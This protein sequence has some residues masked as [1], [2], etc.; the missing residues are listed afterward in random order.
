[1]ERFW[2]EEAYKT[3]KPYNEIRAKLPKHIQ[4]AAR[5]EAEEVL[6]KMAIDELRKQAG[7]TQAALA[8]RMG[9]SQPTVAS[10]EGRKDMRVST[11]HRLVA[12][13]GGSLR[14]SAKL[15]GKKSF[16]LIKP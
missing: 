7:L 9:I 5:R 4:E 1:M 6:L 12:A 2:K 3:M 14:V 13:C 10:L 8:K 16:D 11:L 15:P